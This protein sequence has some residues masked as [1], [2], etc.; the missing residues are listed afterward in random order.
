MKNFNISY[1]VCHENLGRRI[2][3]CHFAKT[4]RTSGGLTA[5]MT[6]HFILP[7]IP[8]SHD[9][10]HTL[11]VW[12][13]LTLDISKTEANQNLKTNAFFFVSKPRP[14]IFTKTLRIRPGYPTKGMGELSET[15]IIYSS[16]SPARPASAKLP[17]QLLAKARVAQMLME[18]IQLKSRSGEATHRLGRLGNGCCS[19]C[20]GRGSNCLNS[21]FCVSPPLFAGIDEVGFWLHLLYC[22][23]SLYILVLYIQK[24]IGLTSQL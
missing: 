24:T 20:L 3:K 13:R 4:L 15:G 22:K 17:H 23:S 6:P 9:A 5:L 16:W 8:Q 21:L 1:L 10:P 18:F 2:L 11:W 19:A 14:S 12:P 7:R